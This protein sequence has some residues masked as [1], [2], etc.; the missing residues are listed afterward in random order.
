MKDTTKK[1]RKPKKG[2]QDAIG[3][4]ETRADAHAQKDQP[5]AN[6]NL[7]DFAT[8]TGSSSTGSRSSPSG[9]SHNKTQSRLTSATRINTNGT[10][11]TATTASSASTGV[12]RDVSSIF[13]PELSRQFHSLD[14]AKEHFMKLAQR[15]GF[16]LKV[17]GSNFDQEF[18]NLACALSGKY[19]PPVQ[20]G[21]VRKRVN[22]ISRLTDCPFHIRFSRSKANPMHPHDKGFIVAKSSCLA[23]NHPFGREFPTMSAYRRTKEDEDWIV[24]SYRQGIPNKTIIELFEA[25]GE[26]R[27]LQDYTIRNIK[28][29][30]DKME[31]EAAAA[32]AAAAGATSVADAQ[33]NKV[34]DS[35]PEQNT[36]DPILYQMDLLMQEITSS[37][38][39]R[40]K[41]YWD[42]LEAKI[43]SCRLISGGPKVLK[44]RGAR[45]RAAWSAS[46]SPV[47]S[48]KR[49]RNG[50]KNDNDG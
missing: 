11:S 15:H 22:A 3:A 2:S 13:S 32:A 29:R 4:S 49:R 21:T 24:E 23:H 39:E 43:A 10:A 31:E 37:P 40:R 26:G 20:P 47:I 6:N 27:A 18:A 14:A 16:S 45:N 38:A 44:A 12:V 5:Q 30:Y 50:L 28:N 17:R 46:P 34:D 41:R 9:A 19:R 48:I 35:G 8:S 1:T 25:K 36:V 33:E 42:A 7:D